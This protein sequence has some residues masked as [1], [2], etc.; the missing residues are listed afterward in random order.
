MQKVAV[1]FIFLL[2]FVLVRAQ[3]VQVEYNY[4]NVGDCIFGAH[5][6]AKTPLYLQM[7]FTNLEYTS[8]RE[9]LP[10]IKKLDPG[11]NTLFTLARESE[12]SA[13][14]FIFEIKTFR[15]DP[16]PKVNLDF[17]YLV[18]F[19]P[20]TEIKPVDVNSIA[21]FWGPEEP[22]GWKASGFLASQG[23]PVFAARQ[24]QVVEITGA[25]RAGNSQTW[26]NTLS[27]AITLLQPD[28]TL[29]IYKNVVD[30][31]NSLKLNQ[32]IQAGEQ[33]GELAAGANE[34]VIVIYHYSLSSTGLQ[35]IIPS[36]L[37]E[38]GKTEIVNSAQTIK[39]VHPDEVRVL[40]MTKKEQRQYLKK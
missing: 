26:Y 6:Q 21:G 32:K 15:S 33:M 9:E 16:A 17:P 13:P 30:K 40:E 24:G 28:G 39:V 3:L 19:A 12:E 29:I 36:F 35:F 8:F 34:L 5:N 4:N 1:L 27:N 31:S 11:Y 14:Q 20:G 22:K 7:W 18:P 10:Y 2:Q 38:P 37:T 25:S 23:I